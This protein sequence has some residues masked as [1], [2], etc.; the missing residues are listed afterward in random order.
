MYVVLL[1]LG[2]AST[3]AGLVLVTSGAAHDG[4]SAVTPGAIAAVGGL[5]LIGL[6]LVVRELQRIERA[7]A[8]RPMPRASRPGEAAERANGPARVTFPPKPKAESHPQAPPLVA[9]GVPAPPE[10]AAFESLR[11]KFPTLVRL[12][13]APVVEETD[14]SLLPGPQPRAEEVVGEVENRAAVGAR[15]N[16]AAPARLAARLEVSNR[17][18]GSPER[19]KGSMFDAF[20]PKGQRVRRDGQTATAHVVAAPAVEPEHTIEPA[21]HA[22]PAPSEPRPAAAERP[23]PPPVS[24]LKSGVVEGM[25][26]T[27][28]SDGSIEAQLPQGLLRF[29]SITELRNHIEN[30]S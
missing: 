29:G 9:T 17:P 18:S 10:Q 23:A 1:L 15:G 11:D 21:P 27:L 2:A 3:A 4:V 14:V 6:G 16:S 26:Y 28:Y 30:E 7:L 22:Q 25:A 8:A 20:W 24:I 12:D 13:N 5:I 19:P